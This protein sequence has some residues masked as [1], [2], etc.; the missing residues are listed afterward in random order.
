MGRLY[1]FPLGALATTAA[2]TSSTPT[3]DSHGCLPGETWDRIDRFCRPAPRP[4]PKPVLVRATMMRAVPATKPAPTDTGRRRPPITTPDRSWPPREALPSAGDR[5]RDSN[6]KKR[7]KEAE[8]AAREAKKAA[9]AAAAAATR[10][11]AE[12]AEAEAARLKAEAE[13]AAAAA[14]QASVDAA[15]ASGGGGGGGAAYDPGQ[16]S[17]AT[18]ELEIF[19]IPEYTEPAPTPA[20][21]KGSSNTDTLILLG[22]AALVAYLVLKK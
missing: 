21:T 18:P 4:A 17:E 1:K 22:G 12:K 3:R 8:A 16:E 6:A 7:K 10:E 15:N 13:A 9:E 19:D 5:K 20:V 11:E 14:E 2:P